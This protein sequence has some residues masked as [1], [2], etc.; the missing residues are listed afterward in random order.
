ML[1][2]HAAP[3]AEQTF[4][5]A[6]ACHQ[7]GRF[8]QAA[9]LY[10]AVLE[11][12]P[13]H[14]NSHYNL[15]LLAV[16]A[17]QPEA[18][19]PHFLAALDADPACGRYWYHYIQTLSLT[20]QH[21]AA[22]ELLAL[23]RQQGLQGPE[24]DEL[25]A[26][27]QTGPLP[28][29]TPCADAA[30]PQCYT[31][32]NAQQQINH[33]LALFD[34]QQ[35]AEAA[36]V[37]Q[38]ITSTFPDNPMGWK[39]LG[40]ALSQLG[41]SAEALQPMRQAVALAPNDI[42]AHYNLGVTQQNI[43][44][45]QEAEASYRHALAIDPYY[46]HAHCNLGVVLQAIGQT[47]AAKSCYRLAIQID[48][49]YTK[50]LNNLGALLQDQGKTSEALSCYRRALQIDPHNAQGHYNISVS[51]KH[52]GQLGEAEVHCRKAL[53]QHPNFPDAHFH[54]GNILHDSGHLDE[55]AASFRNA[56]RIKPD[57]M[58]ALNNLALLLNTQ[59][60]PWAALDT[61]RQSLNLCETAQAKTIFT[62]CIK[63]V[64]FI[65]ADSEIVA[66]L[67]RALSEPWD[68]P[69]EM[70]AVATNLLLLDPVIAGCV[71]R[72]TQ[73][74]PA[75]LSTE[76]LF[77]AHG[78]DSL[79]ANPLLCALLG[80]TPICHTGMEQFLTMARNCLLETA[81]HAAM[82]GTLSENA[83]RFYA[84]LAS[85][86]FINEYVFAFTDNERQVVNTLKVTLDNQLKYADDLPEI[87]LIAAAA[88][89]PLHKLAHAPKLLERAWRHATAIV[90][91]QVQE[92][93]IEQQLRSSLPILTD[94]DDGISLRVQQQYEENPYP[95]WLSIAP[96]GTPQNI[97]AYLSQKFPL[98][99]F[100]RQGQSDATDILI[101][102]C[103]TG[104]HSIATA[105]R[106]Q[107]ARILA[108]DL[109][110]S[111]L[112]YAKRKTSELNLT[113]IDYAQADL[114]KLP[115]LGRSF[116]V[117][118]SVG[119]L[120]HLAD[121]WQGWRTLLSMLRPGGFMKL[122]FYS[123][124]ARRHIPAIRQFIAAG[125]YNASHDSIRQC[126]QELLPQKNQ[127]EFGSILQSPDFFS[128][129]TCRDLL[130]HVQEHCMTLSDIAAFIR[131][132][133]LQFLGF[134]IEAAIVQAY[135]TRFPNDPA[136]TNLAHWQIF[137]DENPD[138]FFSMYQFWVHKPQQGCT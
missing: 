20:N 18:A 11:T 122:G 88:Y 90:T 35:F 91:Q 9:S 135:R 24:V 14:P 37:A 105:M 42:E 23:A 27:L 70:A 62:A 113:S 121:P 21:D 25:T 59:S 74:W 66:L 124:I 39:A 99:A 58:E 55:A 34:Q 117:I 80:A 22:C 134:E 123:A 56:L 79:G 69:S 49:D 3:T 138:T 38:A 51:Y 94:I 36:A 32:D 8:Q 4:E 12:H 26:R 6:V 33:V 64:R 96:A 31:T 65:H 92:H 110:R 120:H 95:R 81:T 93:T 52:L 15:G 53:E 73:A 17:G 28:E 86:C 46:A 102:G 29:I 125:N 30:T 116:N 1:S 5:E 101:A 109:S 54:L 40:A 44:Q 63:Q 72:A 131:T 126:R 129:S 60:H 133:S 87:S 119:V 61:I 77:G 98:A 78:L 111:S 75:P 132:H 19:L 67:V 43:G 114:L 89:L 106:T 118:E 57:Y 107:H 82:L 13:T 100:S 47:S 83:L 115:Q 85:Q 97:T 71:T 68:R 108:I 45:M 50:A 112:A 84:A 137:E 7:Y 76:N 136:A 128:L 41:K 2:A 103:G 16:Q 104:Q 130:F 10:H 48:P 127:A